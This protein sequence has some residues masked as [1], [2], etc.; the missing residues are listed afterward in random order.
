MK[1]TLEKADDNFLFELENSEGH[2]IYLNDNGKEKSQ[3]ISP[4]EALLMALVGCGSMD[5]AAILKKQQ[6]KI[7]S[8]KATVEGE[9]IPMKA[10]HPFQKIEITYSFEGI[11]DPQKAKRAVKLSYEKYCS[12]AMS[13]NPEIKLCFGIKI[14]GEQI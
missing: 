3:A 13:L 8:F 6:Q 11:I 14:N 4:M 12:V 5:I 9:R 2:K 7:T 10:A 1:I